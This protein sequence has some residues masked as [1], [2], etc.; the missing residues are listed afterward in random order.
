LPHHPDAAA[1]RTGI[2]LAVD[3]DGT[4]LATDTLFEAIAETIRRQ[5]L[6]T[7]ADLARLPF[8]IAAAKAR[9]Q[10]R[11]HIDLSS[12]PVNA[13]VLAYCRSE[14]ADGREVWIASAA[15]QSVVSAIRERFSDI[16]DGALGSDG[17][18]N[19]KGPAKA[20]MLRE[21]FPQGFEYIGDSPA[22]YPV[23]KAA[24]LASHVGGGRRRQAR[25][26]AAGTEV[27]RSFNRPGRG[28]ADWVGALR[29]HQWMKNG[30][31]FIVPALAG[32]ITAPSVLLGCL[33]AFILM[34]IMASGTYILNDLLDL[35]A[36][37]RHPSKRA[38]PF[39][40]G[41]IKLWRG[42]V[43]AP[44]LIAAALLGAAALS[45]ALAM[46]MIVYLSVTLAYSM[47][48][49]QAPLLDVLIIASLF[50]LRLFMGAVLAA[51]EVSDWLLVF[52][53]FLFFSLALAKRH[54]ELVRAA[55]DAGAPVAVRGYSTDDRPLTLNLGLST[56]AASP[57]ILS[58]YIVSGAW[59]SGL[60]AAPG[61]LW[62]APFA[63]ALW[64]MRIWLLA[65]RG[66]LHDD[67]VVFAIRDP[68]SV[69]LA[70]TI[71][72]AFI[73]AMVG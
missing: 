39:A 57:L 21:A 36:D 69:C 48:L 7:I 59:P 70:A 6:Q 61:L 28:L 33:M 50:T 41:S 25:I 11:A 67:P 49:K 65:S 53:L 66:Q 23:W 38:R 35:A 10:Q 17:A 72:A 2:P 4:L 19:N 29:I 54:V 32:A 37:R 51:A 12:L 45:P 18:T 68:A 5:P 42:F 46:L 52:S 15:D 56:A 64:L 34:G 31:V 60:Y 43:V 30:L 24:R 22:D 62:I 71:G 47:R 16:F 8:G 9:I 1:A 27:A 14:R 40:S 73:L 44:L 3:L 20:R 55:A 13:D 63:L 58:L 26:E